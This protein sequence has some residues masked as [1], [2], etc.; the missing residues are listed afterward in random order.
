MTF[1]IGYVCIGL[2]LIAVVLFFIQQD[3]YRS[4]KR[5]KLGLDERYV[6]MRSMMHHRMK[7]A[8]SEVER[9]TEQYNAE[10]EI[11]A[12]QYVKMVIAHSGLK[13]NGYYFL[14]LSFFMAVFGLLIGWMIGNAWLIMVLPVGFLFLPWMI[15]QWRYKRLQFQYKVLSKEVVSQVSHVYKTSGDMM[16]SVLY[17]LDYFPPSYQLL[18]QQ[19]LKERER[20]S[21]DYAIENMIKQVHDPNFRL[22]LNIFKISESLGVDVYQELTMIDAIYEDERDIQ[23]MLK[24]EM[25]KHKIESVVLA[26]IAIVILPAYFVFSPEKVIEILATPWA[27]QI[28][29]IGVT[30]VMVAILM[31][32]SM[33]NFDME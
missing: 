32:P 16:H 7:D 6:Q 12:F 2:S 29:S 19:F 30:M 22:F 10:H 8:N 33:F 26:I 28:I 21:F 27:N 17:S 9:I 31:L 20:I 4:L 1:T 18:F 23:E 11:R 24:E 25:N 13:L 5:F 3:I 15:L 14:A